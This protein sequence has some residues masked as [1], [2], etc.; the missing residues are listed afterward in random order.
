MNSGLGIFRDY[1][2]AGNFYTYE[3]I[4]GER[5]WIENGI[6]SRI[7]RCLLAEWDALAVCFVRRCSRY[8]K[9]MQISIF[10]LCAYVYLVNEN[11][12]VFEITL[13]T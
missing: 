5:G 10:R 9:V 4:K 2:G 8:S 1:F 11:I 12:V 3:N 6:S 7:L 13:V